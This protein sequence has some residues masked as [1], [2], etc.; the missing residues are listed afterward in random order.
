MVVGNTVPHALSSGIVQIWQIDLT[1]PGKQ[2]CYCRRFL[3]PDE[4]QRANRFYFERDRNSFIVARAGLRTILAR[5]LCIAPEEVVFSYAAKGKPEL[6]PGLQESGLKF[7]LSHSRD[8]ALLALTLHSCIGV[9][10]EFIDPESTSDEIASRFFSRS[11]VNR[12]HSLR[13]EERPT[14]FYKCWTRKEAYVKAVGEG[15]SLALNSFDVAFEPGVPPDVS[16]ASAQELSRW[17]LYD[18]PAP[19]GYAAAIAIEGREHKLQ[20]RGWDWT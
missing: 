13:P 16:R 19:Q 18:V 11:E 7:N 1:T 17:S 12:L 2:I 9:D 8:W 14:A 3:S 6:A 4:N 5:S 15:L 10:I 20:L